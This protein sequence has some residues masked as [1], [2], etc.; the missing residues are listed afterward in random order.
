MNPERLLQ[1]FDR[2]S[3]APDA[4]PRLR[5]FI[6]D[7]AVRG[8]LVLQD[9]NDEPAEELLKRLTQAKQQNG[10]QSRKGESLSNSMTKM[11]RCHSRFRQAGFGSESALCSR[12]PAVSRKP[13]YAPR[14]ATRSPTLES[15]MS[16]EGESI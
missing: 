2:I 1:Y 8:K 14:R 7:L 3:E 4:I 10:M 13:L 15:E 6:L 16:I 5:N 9:R 11:V 12:L